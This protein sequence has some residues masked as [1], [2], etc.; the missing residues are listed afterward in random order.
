MRVAGSGFGRGGRRKDPLGGP[1]GNG[2]GQEGAGKANY[3][4]AL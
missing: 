2:K 4:R 3:P 1:A